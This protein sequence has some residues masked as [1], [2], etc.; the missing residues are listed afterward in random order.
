MSHVDRVSMFTD[1]HFGAHNNSEQHN[2]DCLDYINWFCGE[3]ANNKSGAVV[4]GGD[5]HE[6][7]NAINGL[8]LDYS[9]LAAKK[10]NE[11]EV[12]IYFDV[13]NHDLYYR[14]NRSIYTT[15]FFESF[16]N[17]RVIGEPTVI[18]NLGPRGS[19][20]CPFLFPDEYPSLLNYSHIPVWFFHAEFRGFVITGESV[21]MDH[22]PSAEDYSAPLHIFCGHYHKRQS[23]GNVVYI[24]NT[25]PTNYADANDNDRG[26]MHYT[27][28]QDDIRFVNYDGPTY[29]TTTLSEILDD[30]VEIKIR[31][32]IRCLADIEMADNEKAVLREDLM[33]RHALREF[34]FE[35]PPI[36]VLIEDTNMDLS[37]LETEST[38]NI[39]LTLM[40]RIPDTPQIKSAKLKD[41]YRELIKRVASK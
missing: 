5:W 30:S 20:V 15:N 13:G 31:S 33:A 11:L 35:D 1:I 21:V 22:G 18:E 28:S 10:L 2:Q 39:V 19:L 38:D 25:F 16:K 3:V 24:G 34:S 7:R 41:I 12:P 6:H 40:D 32:C 4:F 17:F 29:M 36:D 27:Y 8:T 26:L 9:Y 37:G 14:N 23:R